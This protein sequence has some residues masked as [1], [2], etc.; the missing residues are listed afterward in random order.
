M[1][2]SGSFSARLLEFFGEHAQIEVSSESRHTIYETSTCLDVVFIA[3]AA[4]GNIQAAE[5]LLHVCVEGIPLTLVRL[6]EIRERLATEAEWNWRDLQSWIPTNEILHTA[7]A[8]TFST[9]E[10]IRT[11]LPYELCDLA[12]P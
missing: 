4:A 9:P 5:A 2:Q 12:A 8:W 3:C 6:F 11:I 7:P 1:H 10:V